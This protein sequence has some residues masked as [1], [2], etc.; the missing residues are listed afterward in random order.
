MADLN[1]AQEGGFVAQGFA[2]QIFNPLSILSLA[3]GKKVS[4]VRHLNGLR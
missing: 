2:A 3:R 1:Q 4:V